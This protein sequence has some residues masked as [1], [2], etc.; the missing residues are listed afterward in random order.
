MKLR[1]D[2]R[3]VDIA[4]L[5]NTV[6]MF[7]DHVVFLITAWQWS[8]WRARGRTMEISA[9]LL[10]MVPDFLY[11]ARLVSTG[12]AKEIPRLPASLPRLVKTGLSCVPTGF[13]RLP[14]L[15]RGHFWAAAEAMLAYDLG[16]LERKFAGEVI[17]H[18]NL[19]D[20][21]WS[22][23][24]QSFLSA[25]KDKT[26]GRE[27]WGIATQQITTA[28]SSCARWGLQPSRIMY[29]TG[30]SRPE[31]MLVETARNHRFNLTSWTVDLTQ[32]P[33]ELLSQTE[34]YDIHRENDNEW[35]VTYEAGLL[36]IS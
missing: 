34:L 11:Y 31:T 25:F 26:K 30:Y 13:A 23:E 4:D 2:L 28:L 15:A 33:K 9:R 7:P 5:D 14:G 21:A 29:T 17:L 10:V 27:G 24:R 16:L 22:F 18:Y 8:A 12:Q 6:S 19:S 32:W 3:N 36:L 35:L 20:F 1:I